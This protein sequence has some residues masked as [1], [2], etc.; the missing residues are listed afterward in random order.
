M[1]TN[2]C[3]VVDIWEGSLEIDEAVLKANGVAGIAIR[4]N[5]MR[6]GHHRDTN[7][8]KQWDQAA[9]FVRFPYFVYNPWVDAIGNFS[10]L[11]ANAPRGIATIAIDIEVI[12]PYYS[13][14]VYATEVAKFLEMCKTRWKT[15]VY[16]GQGFLQILSSWPKVD[17][18]WAQYPLHTK[19]FG[20]VTDWSTLKIALDNPSLSKPF[21]ASSI[22]GTLK[23]WQ[24]SGDKL[25]LP[26]SIRK[27]DVNL[28]FGTPAELAAYINNTPEPQ[29][30]KTFCIKDDLW[31]GVEPVGTRPGIR[32]GLP[33]TVRIRGGAGKVKLSQKWMEYIWNINQPNWQYQF[34]SQGH[35]KD[36]VG[37]HNSGDGNVVEQ[38]TFS[39][40]IIR[41]VQVGG[42]VAINTYFNNDTPPAVQKP[43]EETLDTKIHLFSTQY[44]NHLDMQTNGRLPRIVV[45]AN[46]GEGLYMNIND[47]APVDVIN[48]LVKIKAIPSLRLRAYPSLKAATLKLYPYGTNLHVSYVVKIGAAIWGKVSGGWIAMLYNNQWMTD[49]RP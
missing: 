44:L 36:A 27:I 49:W 2:T 31:A 40:N 23:M 42:N 11:A 35:L 30:E 13:K 19:Y 39:G 34:E 24:F 45:I 9:N 33:S 7:F 14:A 15:I 32:V 25:T 17:Y 3:L 12:K 8:D 48:R 29:V 20:N 28:F 46:P 5:D 37:W 41:G 10:W 26:G 21:N 6:G 47:L 22:P 16:T 43:I 4:L 18:W 1:K 38:V